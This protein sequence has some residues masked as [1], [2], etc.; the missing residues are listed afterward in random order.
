MRTVAV[1]LACL[2][3]ILAVVAVAAERW[4]RTRGL[5]IAAQRLTAE[6]G[7]GQ[8]VEL[9]VPARP[10]LPALLTGSGVE[11]HIAARDVPVGDDG[12]LRSV[13]ATFGEVRVRPG[14]RVVT[15]DLGIFAATVDESELARVVPLPGVVS[16]LEVR[17]TGLRVW[18]VLA[19]AVDAEVLVVEGALRIIPDPVQVADLLALPGL[20]AFRRTIEGTGLLLPLPLMPFGAEVETVTFRD[21]QVDVTGLMAPQELPLFGSRG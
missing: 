4:A 11:A 17:A 18:T 10:L 16:R 14:A 12:R 6:L 21:G 8:T 13:T 1:V 19:R 7:A 9:R 20:A 3:V 2:L 15:T 5:A